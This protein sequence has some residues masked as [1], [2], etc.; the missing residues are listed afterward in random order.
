MQRDRLTVVVA[1]LGLGHLGLG[2]W[3]ALG[4]GSFFDALGG[5][6]LRNDH[7]VRDVSTWY[8]ALGAALVAAAARPTWRVPVLAL[9]AAQSALHTINHLLD[10]GD[11][12]PS[13]VGPFDAAAL[14]AITVVLLL[15]VAASRRSVP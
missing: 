14:A 7:Y 11:A 6:G 15:V 12:E 2:L 13:W 8:L 5:F 1:A 9:A 3:Q 10:V 4:P